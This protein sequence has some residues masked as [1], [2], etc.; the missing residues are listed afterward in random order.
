M[1]SKRMNMGSLSFQLILPTLERGQAVYYHTP[2]SVIAKN[3]ASS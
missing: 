3:A 1:I 2:P